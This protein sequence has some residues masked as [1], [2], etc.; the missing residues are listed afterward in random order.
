MKQVIQVAGERADVVLTGRIYS[1]QAGLLR[2]ELVEKVAQGVRRL[3]LDVSR[4]EYLDSSGLS[5]LVT[6]H[7]L[8]ADMDGALVVQ[9]ARGMVGELLKRTRLDRILTIQP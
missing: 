8:A 7:K 3:R 9:G 6:L 1:H 2:D 4:V 5:M